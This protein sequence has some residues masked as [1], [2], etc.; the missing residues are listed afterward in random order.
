MGAWELWSPRTC[1]EASSGTWTLADIFF[2]FL[3][4][5]TT[6]PNSRSGNLIV[7]EWCKEVVRTPS[8]TL[9][10]TE[11]SAK[12][13]IEDIY[14]DTL[15]KHRVLELYPGLRQAGPCTLIRKMTEAVITALRQHGPQS[16][17]TMHQAMNLIVDLPEAT[18]YKLDQSIRFA[19]E[20]VVVNAFWRFVP[21]DGFIDSPIKLLMEWN[22]FERERSHWW[23][24]RKAADTE[25]HVRMKWDSLL[26]DIVPLLH[27]HNAMLHAKNL[28]EKPTLKHTLHLAALTTEGRIYENGQGRSIASECRHIIVRKECDIPIKSRPE[29]KESTTPVKREKKKQ[30]VLNPRDGDPAFA[31]LS[32]EE[33]A[34]KRSRIAVSNLE[35]MGSSFAPKRTRLG[36]GH[37]SDSNFPV[38]QDSAQQSLQ[39]VSLERQRSA[40]SWAEELAKL[41]DIQRS[42]PIYEA[43]MLLSI[44]RTPQVTSNSIRDNNAQPSLLRQSSA[45]WP[46]HLGLSGS[47]APVLSGQK[48]MFD[49]L[50]SSHKQSQSIGE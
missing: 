49:L 44:S 40:E 15:V 9:I 36:T 25:D 35:Q 2:I 12:K 17:K 48:H 6:K 10:S 23:R 42:V 46:A 28:L 30:V 50:N 38:S 34:P 24:A 47:A 4:N 31:S 26:A 27:F 7:P 18:L 3:G 22:N 1:R 16:I 45:E 33:P 14:H 43:N 39:R 19:I 37:T 32:R 13:A 21:V 8:L 29:R 5:M 11:E 20:S 41:G